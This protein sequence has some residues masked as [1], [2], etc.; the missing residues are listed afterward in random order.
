MNRIALGIAEA[1]ILIA[2]L[3]ALPLYAADVL[4]S[5]IPGFNPS[6]MLGYFFSTEVLAIGAI[7]AVV[8]GLSTALRGPIGSG[9]AKIAQGAL[10]VLYF[11][12]LFHG[13]NI[14]MPL[15]IS[16]VT[17]VIGLDLTLMIYILYIGGLLR[18]V[19][20]ALIMI[21]K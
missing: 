19:Q 15:A 8:S 5:A 7:L 12:L 3:V 13:G 14:S 20:G 9:A 11:Y 21:S 6:S 16:N 2:L 4:R 18:V 17:L 1:I 10:G